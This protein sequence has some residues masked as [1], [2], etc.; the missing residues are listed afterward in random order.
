MQA[1]PQIDELRALFSPHSPRPSP[2][3]TLVLSD[4]EVVGRSDGQARWPDCTRSGLFA[5]FIIAATQLDRNPMREYCR[6]VDFRSFRSEVART[7]A[8]RKLRERDDSC[9]ATCYPWSHCRTEFAV[10]GRHLLRSRHAVQARL[11]YVSG[12]ATGRPA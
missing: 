6:C 9:P 2:N 1:R 11:P 5:R 7:R 4:A 12:R 8:R 3:T 10:D